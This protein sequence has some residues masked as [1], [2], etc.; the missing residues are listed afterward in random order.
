MP[1]TFEDE[2]SARAAPGCAA[3]SCHRAYA[4]GQPITRQ[5]V[6]EVTAYPGPVCGLSGAARTDQYFI[7]YLASKRK[8]QSA[9][10]RELAMA[11]RQRVTDGL[12]TR[13]QVRWWQRRASERTA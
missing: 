11:A 3:T 12:L 1:A 8:L 2:R 7:H 5:K 13:E 10:C 9:A 4:L 6:V